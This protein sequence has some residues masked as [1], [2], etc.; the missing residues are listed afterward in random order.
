MKEKCGAYGR[1]I[2]AAVGHLVVNEARRYAG[3]GHIP[4]LEEGTR[5]GPAQGRRAQRFARLEIPK[6]IWQQFRDIAIKREIT[7][8]RYVGILV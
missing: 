3:V 8:A 7:L 5:P 4:P 2:G 1:T 6:E